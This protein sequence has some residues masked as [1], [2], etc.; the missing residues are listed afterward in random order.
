MNSSHPAKLGWRYLLGRRLSNGVT[1]AAAAGICVG[2]AAMIIVL[3]AFNG[4]ESLVKSSFEEIHPIVEIFS[5]EEGRFNP[6]SILISKLNSTNYN[7][8][9]ILEQKAVIRLNEKELLVDVIGLPA[10]HLKSFI[11]LDSLTSQLTTNPTPKSIWLGSGVARNLGLIE[12]NGLNSVELLWP[13]SKEK[14]SLNFNRTFFREVLSP[15]A[16]FRANSQIDS[17]HILVSLSNLNLWGQDKRWSSIQI[18]ELPERINSLNTIHE[19][20]NQV[21]ENSVYEMRTPEDQEAAIFKVMKSEGLITSAIL[22]FVVLLASLGLYSSTIL[23]G[24]EREPQSAI[25]SALGLSEKKIR[26]SFFWSGTWVSIVGSIIGL[27]FGGF[28]IWAQTVFGLIPLGDGYIVEAYPVEF[29]FLQS[30][31]VCAYVILIGM[32]LSFFAS[33]KI[34]VNTLRLREKA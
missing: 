34:A 22:A 20:I 25:L 9:P 13:K 4:L 15:Q 12:L 11:W 23:S 29:S 30:M 5:K 19:E 32:I 17:K 24:M 21:L 7:W 8:F 10:S 3:S 31:Q 1:R 26:Q 6:D 14:L 16:I 2:T 33:Q 28:A 18:W 27:I